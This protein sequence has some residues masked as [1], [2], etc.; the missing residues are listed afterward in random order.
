MNFELHIR[1]YILPKLIIEL[2]KRNVKI[3][4][5]VFNWKQSIKQLNFLRLEEV[6]K[7][8]E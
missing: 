3:K 8:N 5:A 6:I 2:R 4:D 1:N 7:K